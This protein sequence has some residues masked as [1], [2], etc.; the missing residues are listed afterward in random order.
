[1]TYRT[2]AS[3][4]YPV[5]ERELF[6]YFISEAGWQ[7]RTGNPSS[8]TEPASYSPMIDVAVVLCVGWS[9]MMRCFLALY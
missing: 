8:H 7:V 1:M 2:I 4:S 3:L 9:W 5:C 6:V